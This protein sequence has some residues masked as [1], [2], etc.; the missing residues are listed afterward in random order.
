MAITKGYKQ[1]LDEANARITTHTVAEA[2]SLH[3]NDEY[4]FVD[5][6]DP[7]ELER[8]GGNAEFRSV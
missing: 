3:G 5:L 7:R 6:R 2:V 4:V 8:G 1:L